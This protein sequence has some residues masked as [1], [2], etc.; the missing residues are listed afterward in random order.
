MYSSALT[1]RY[2]LF[3]SLTFPSLDCSAFIC[4]HHKFSY[5]LH[6]FNGVY[7]SYR[8]DLFIHHE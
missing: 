2:S 4:V 6:I 1:I 7:T 8:A 5:H 3:F